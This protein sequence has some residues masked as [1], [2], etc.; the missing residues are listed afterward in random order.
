MDADAVTRRHKDQGGMRFFSEVEHPL[1]S[2]RLATQ[3]QDFAAEQV[4][5]H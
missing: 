4:Y 1:V 5:A 3:R 2:P